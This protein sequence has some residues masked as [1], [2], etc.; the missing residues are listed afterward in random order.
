MLI[1]AV[2]NPILHFSKTLISYTCTQ[3]FTVILTE[4][5]E[6]SRF[7]NG[8]PPHLTLNYDFF[9]IRLSCI[10]KCP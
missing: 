1:T 5:L 4:L 3:A 9:V 7:F 2:S 6:D 10:G 8:D